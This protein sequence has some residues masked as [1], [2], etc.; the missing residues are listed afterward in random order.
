MEIEESIIDYSE[1]TDSDIIFEVD[2]NTLYFVWI[3]PKS[4]IVV[5]ICSRI[6]S[7]LNSEK[8]GIPSPNNIGIVVIVILSTRLSMIK[9]LIIKP[10]SI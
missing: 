10:P 5:V 1:L 4:Y 2:F 8:R 3:N 7:C 6:I 9:L